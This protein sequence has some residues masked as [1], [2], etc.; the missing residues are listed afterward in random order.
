MA[1]DI[2]SVHLLLA[3]HK[4]GV[5]FGKVLMFGRQNVN[6]FPATLA[7]MLKQ[8]GLPHEEVA[9]DGSKDPDDVYAEPLFRA[10]GA[11][12]IVSLDAS[13]YQGSSF[14]HDM[15]LPI[16]E[17]FKA[18]FDVVYDGGSIE[19]VF[20]APQ[21]L[22]NCLEMLKVG[23]N[24]FVHTT[25]NNC[26]GHGFYQFSPEFFFR[27]LS[28]ENGFKLERLI[29][30]RVGPYNRWF[31]VSDPQAIQMRVE[32]ISFGQ[33]YAMADAKKVEDVPIFAKM[34]QQSDLLVEWA[35]SGAPGEPP[36]E[37]SLVKI[38]KRVAKV[39]PRVARVMHVIRIGVL[40]Y[41]TFSLFN[42]KFFKPIDKE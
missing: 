1:I 24:Y 7:E 5:K 13:H 33:V 37:S 19:H 39:F 29:V 17:K 21:A 2:N 23:G 11:A 28:K 38:E 27:A 30:H 32:L 40:F 15:N 9:A 16:P 10:L 3:A 6:V 14:E 25:A 12:E 35:G 18:Q 41:S 22:K 26:F 20:N 31:E 42:R 4:R 34:P 8:R 36:K